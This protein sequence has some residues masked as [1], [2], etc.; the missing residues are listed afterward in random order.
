MK[1]E[2]R[3]TFPRP[4]WG[5]FRRAR[6]AAVTV[7]V[8]VAVL[9]PAPPAHANHLGTVTITASTGYSTQGLVMGQTN[10]TVTVSV[11][12]NDSSVNSIQ[13]TTTPTSTS[14]TQPLQLSSSGNSGSGPGAGT[15]TAGTPSNGATGGTT[16]IT[17]T[18]AAG[19]TGTATFTLAV[20]SVPA[21]VA[22]RTDNFSISPN[23]QSGAHLGSGSLKRY[24]L[25]ITSVSPP[26]STAVALDTLDPVMTVS[27]QASGSITLAAGST[28]ISGDAFNSTGTEGSMPAIS[29]LG[30]GTVT[31][32][33]A[34]ITSSTGSK[35]FSAA[36]SNGAS[37]SSEATA[38]SYSESVSVSTSTSPSLTSVSVTANNSF[39][40]VGLIMGTSSNTLTASVVIG[41]VG[42]GPKELTSIKITSSESSGGSALVFQNSGSSGTGAGGS[43][44]AASAGTGTITFNA[45]SAVTT[46]TAT[47]TISVSSVPAL[48]SNGTDTLTAQYITE[49]TT[50]SGD[51]TSGSVKRY[52]LEIT[53][54]TP[55]ASGQAAGV[56]VDTILT[57][58]NRS[59][60]SITLHQADTAI[61][62]SAFSTTG[63][64]GSMPTIASGASGTVTYDDALVT[65]STGTK[66][67]E[68]EAATSSQT[69]SAPDLST[70]IT[71]GSSSGLPSISS[72][73]EA[74]PKNSYDEPG[75]VM[76]TSSNSLTLPVAIG[77]IGSGATDLDKIRITSNETGEGSDLVFQT[78]GSSGSGAGGT[79]TASAAS[80][81]QITFDAPTGVTTGTV[82]FTISISSVPSLAEDGEDEFSAVYV[83]SDSTS[84]GTTDASDSL[85]RYSLEISDISGVD[86]EEEPGETVD[87]EMDV[88][89]HSTGSVTL[90]AS[91]TTLSGTVFS[92]TGTEG[93]MPT[94]ASGATDDVEYEDA[95]ITT[96]TGEKTLTGDA[97]QSSAVTSPTF[98]SEVDVDD[99]ADPD[100]TIS[101][102]SSPLTVSEDAS[103][104]IEW[105]QSEEG[106]YDLRIG[107]EE[108]DEGTEIESGSAALGFVS[109]T[110]DGDDL[111]PG[112]NQI[113][114]CVEDVFGDIGSALTPVITLD[115]TDPEGKITAAT[116][117][118][119]TAMFS[120]SSSDTGAE[121]ECQIDD[122]IFVYCSP[123]YRYSGLSDGT[124]TFTLRVRDDAANL[125]SPVTFDFTIEGS[126]IGRVETVRGELAAGG[127]L[128]TDTE[129]DYVTLGDPLEVTVNSPVAGEVTI[130]EQHVSTSDPYW[131]S[132]SQNAI[133]SAPE[134]SAVSP[135]T[136]EFLIHS[137]LIEPSIP[138]R[139]I[140]IARDEVPVRRCDKESLS[141]DPDPC[142]V[143]KQRDDG[144]L[145]LTVRTSEASEW[146]IGVDRKAPAAPT[147]FGTRP[148]S[149]A[150]DQTPRVYGN[151]EAGSRV[152]LYDNGSCSGEPIAKGSAERFE[153]PGIKV[154]VPEQSFRT[155][156]ATAKDTA[157][158]VSDC[159]STNVTY[160][161]LDRRGPRPSISLTRHVISPNRDGRA[162]SFLAD[163]R[164]DETSEWTFDIAPSS[165]PTVPLF[166]R[167]GTGRKFLL[168]WFGRANGA[169]VPEGRYIWTLEA[170]DDG[171]NVA[172]PRVGDIRVDVTK[173]RLSA[174]RVSPKKIGGN[175]RVARIKVATSEAGTIGVRILQRGRV[176]RRLTLAK[177][178]GPDAVTFS[179]NGRGKAG[180]TLPSG[181]YTI[182][183]TVADRGGNLVRRS[184][185]VQVAG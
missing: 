162:E 28:S 67:V 3:A 98:S 175:R 121:F 167:S 100:I 15:W 125:S 109:E 176:V 101:R 161:E 50:Q 13:I 72:V 17:F 84:G 169:V 47:F 60:G 87:A 160:E 61:S 48:A 185:R 4:V 70:S 139:K 151:A 14:T 105:V 64:E 30:T 44:T 89:N 12:I 140:V 41:A 58:R 71:I 120:F 142:W 86:S 39:S 173:P 90:S 7:A 93:S 122:E 36:A 96:S 78:T 158:N 179:W 133:V 184:T 45:S 51:V 129:R 8:L 80:S 43:W 116:I 182:Q 150:N 180:Q 102:P 16:S 115:T 103:I 92:S 147:L 68:G 75:F 111:E 99:E 181:R 157:G 141:A 29:S 35:T 108:C 104:V 38:P 113:L 97:G 63:T 128:T 135:I 82:T 119:D 31:Y 19:S 37:G 5:A 83:A 152:K 33:N 18:R 146:D 52:A 123:P 168:R 127:S 95:V 178:K 34:V 57:V 73:G 165:D 159:S 132:I 171:D 91:Q 53:S 164:F 85:I 1:G 54:I 144:N 23:G 6:V 9:L 66:T 149:P 110:I 32:D 143:S 2:R 76:G 183:V 155:F 174:F 26:D 11:V 170:I 20:S 22:D 59:T 112:E 117:E 65:S 74:D 166:T 156:A 46:G 136:I 55:P 24:S 124:H 62:G 107:T 131:T 153:S 79:W 49:D 163:V 69:Q 134:A 138:Q 177:V 40:P 10:K 148:S 172:T 126:T 114:I 145:L 130:Q 42:T 25:E 88:V 137:S 118:F 21:A 94:I 81:G 27:N 154:R 77:S 106:D 56:L